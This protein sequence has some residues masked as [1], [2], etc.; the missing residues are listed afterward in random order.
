MDDDGFG[1]AAH[2][3]T[4]REWDATS[5]HAVSTPHQGWGAEILGRLA[6]NGDETVLDLGCGT[7]RVT[8][9]LLD[10]LP[11]GHVIGVD[12]SAAMVAEA[13]R[14][15]GSQR[16]TF[17]QSDLLALQIDEPADAAVSSAT[18]HWIADHDTLFARVRAALRPGAPFVAQCGGRGNIAT[19]VAAVDAVSVR[20][21]FAG[22]FAGWPG[23][24]NY[25]GP[26]ETAQRLERA[27]F[28][29][30]RCWLKESPQR[31]QPLREF[32]QTVSLGSH[33]QRLPRELHDPFLD[34]VVA[35]LGPDP[36]HD[37][38]RLNLVARAR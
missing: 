13:Q 30:E 25:A 24:W 17:L 38:V 19:V 1:P 18:F 23:P 37:Y 11:E 36:V 10:L 8:A 9:Q 31:P 32:L 29:V 34:A 12:G 26:E 35:E 15:L 20:E 3:P 6:L 5:Y 28:A 7:G 14:L 27:G 33:L 2:P 22:H 21:P 16:A 4:P